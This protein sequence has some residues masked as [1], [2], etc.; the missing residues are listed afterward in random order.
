MP[1]SVLRGIFAALGGEDRS[2]NHSVQ[3]TEKA[4][5]RI[6]QDELHLQPHQHSYIQKVRDDWHINVVFSACLLKD[7]L[8]SVNFYFGAGGMVGQ[9]LKKKKTGSKTSDTE[10]LKLKKSN[11]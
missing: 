8:E 3:P 11:I 10:N 1:N 7:Y 2:V 4:L 5:E 6:A 9:H